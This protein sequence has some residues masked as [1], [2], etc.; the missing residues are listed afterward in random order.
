MSFECEFTSGPEVPNPDEQAR[1]ILEIGDNDISE[2]RL[3]AAT[4]VR[5]ARSGEGIRYWSQVELALGSKLGELV[6]SAP[7]LKREVEE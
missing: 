6:L 7:Y 4:N 5:F 2:A 1:V 3:I